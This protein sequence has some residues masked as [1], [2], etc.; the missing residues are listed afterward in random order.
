MGLLGT[1]LSIARRGVRH[2]DKLRELTRAAARMG[3]CT[4]V[5]TMLAASI[6]AAVALPAEKRYLLPLC[7][8]AA[9]HLPFQHLRLSLLAVD[10]GSASFARY[11]LNRLFF[12]G[13]FPL[14]LG[15]AWL[16]D[17]VSLELVVI[18][19]VLQPALACLV[20]ILSRREWPF[21]R[22]A[23][24]TM[25]TL[26]REGLPYAVA[27]AAAALFLQID[28]YAVLFLADFETQGYYLVAVPVAH[29]MV[30]VPNAIGLF[31]FRRGAK[32]GG[33]LDR[34]QLLRTGAAIIALQCVCAGAFA[35]V[36]DPVI[37][38]LYGEAFAQ[39]A[40]FA[41]LLIPAQAVHGMAVTAEAFLQ[42]RQKSM[43]GVWSR[44]IAT[45]AGAV[46]IAVLYP[47]YGV[48]G[49]PWAM[50]VG[51]VI[52]STIIGVCIYRFRDQEAPTDDDGAPAVEELEEEDI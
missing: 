31:S 28:V 38:T 44:L 8:L 9:A 47:K 3:M 7:L 10:H 35:L 5:V 20:V 24:P 4:G 43:I 26:L 27:T 22:P 12:A 39:A 32:V 14:M 11:N 30:A 23:F 36:I 40:L 18:F 49:L 37:R 48:W 42:A 21:A 13:I 17:V 34:G 25:R 2:P 33:R 29:L 45:A 19:A 52:N 41:A 1:Q 15:V 16:C 50:L 51:H 6:L 46:T